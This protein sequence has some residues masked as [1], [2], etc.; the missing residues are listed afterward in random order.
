MTLRVGTDIVSV[1][2]LT[3]L[4]EAGGARF[5]GRWFTDEEITYCTGKATP[6]MHFAARVAAKEAVLKVLRSQWDGPMRWREITVVNDG[7]GVPSVELAGRIRQEAAR[8]GVSTLA[9]SMSHCEAYATATVVAD[10]GA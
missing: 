1:E 8:L 4:I 2:R 9:L 5:L 10:D 7:G 6:A 3:R